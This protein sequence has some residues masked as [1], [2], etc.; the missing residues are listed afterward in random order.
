MWLFFAILAPIFWGFGNPIDAALRRTS[1]K[2][3]V[4]MTAVFAVTRLPF[5]LV[6]L[7]LFGGG[8]VFGWPFFWI[9]FSGVI[10]MLGFVFYY[11]AMQLEEVSRVVLI[12]QFQPIFILLI[13]AVMIRESLTFS[14]FAAFLL[15][16]CGS[17]LAAMKK[18]GSKWHFSKAFWLMLLAD[19]MWCFAD[20]IFKKFVVYFPN[21]WSAF[22]VDLLGSS[23]LGAFLFFLPTHRKIYKAFQLNV[24]SWSLV[25][26]SAIFGTLGSLV[27]AY[28]LTLGKASLTTVI[29]GIQPLFAL[30]FSLS[31]H[32]FLKEIPGE[33]LAKTDLLIKFASFVLI[34]GGLIA[35]S[36]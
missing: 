3:D 6:L 36:L 29:I 11:R 19:V 12:L 25:V 10:W 28:A 34:I 18:K 27:F 33:S 31:L 14:Q 1:M 24:R 13:A 2:D 9:F 20:V 21:F 35:L 23:L 26:T 7:F 4:V 8:I 17:I 22:S 15:I 5:A 16:L 30:I 32:H